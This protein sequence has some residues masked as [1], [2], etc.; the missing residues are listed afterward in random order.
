MCKFSYQTS[1]NVRLLYQLIRSKACNELANCGL[2]RSEIKYQIN[3]GQA[4]I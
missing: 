3:V 1:S 2:L 4:N